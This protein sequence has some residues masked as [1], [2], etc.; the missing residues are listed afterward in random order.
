MPTPTTTEICSFISTFA[1]SMQSAISDL[2][3]AM[4]RQYMPQ[5]WHDKINSALTAMNDAAVAL[6][7]SSFIM[8]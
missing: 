7:S 4:D 2:Q 5:E 6:Q 8:P 1:G 3:A